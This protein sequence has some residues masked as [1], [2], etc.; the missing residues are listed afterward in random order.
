VRALGACLAVAYVFASAAG[1]AG[2]G[3]CIHADAGGEG[4]GHGAQAAAPV[5]TASAHHSA[6]PLPCASGEDH[7]Q[8]LAEADSHHGA[9]DP[10]DCLGDCSIAAGMADAPAARSLY[11]A[12]RIASSEFFPS[13]D[14]V[15]TP[16]DQ[17]RLP[18]PNAPPLL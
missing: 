5:H 14:Q 9:S 17:H 16:A 7:A 2:I 10:C 15:E 12:G 11:A 3:G 6:V 13:P 1:A 4:H 18:Y 8:D